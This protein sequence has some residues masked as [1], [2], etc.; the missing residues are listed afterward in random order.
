MS[1]YVLVLD[2]NKRPLDPIHPST[3]RLLLNQQKA[4]VFRRQPFTIIFKEAKP[5]TPTE[6]IQ[7]K[8]D[9]GSKTTGIALVQNN[10]VIWGGELQHRGSEIT[11]C[12]LIR[13]AIRRSRRSRHTRYRQARFLNRTRPKGWLAPSLQHR[14]ETILTWVN[15]LMKFAPIIGISQEL[16]RFDLQQLENPEI[17]GI[18]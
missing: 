15:K 1:N 11:D 2:T 6:P 13:R 8:L 3:A 18:E 5:D 16:V 9:P 7:L 4:A 14:V 17:S 10:K 12:L